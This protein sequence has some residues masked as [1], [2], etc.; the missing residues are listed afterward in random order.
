[1]RDPELRKAAA[2]VD[3]SRTTNEMAHAAFELALIKA[4]NPGHE[5]LPALEHSDNPRLRVI[6][7]SAVGATTLN[8]LPDVGA[9]NAA[10]MMAGARLG[11]VDAL[12]KHGAPT[13]GEFGWGGVTTAIANSV[14]ENAYKPLAT[15]GLEDAPML[16]AKSSAIVTVTNAV[17]RSP[18]FPRLTVE[19]QL[20]NAALSDQDAQ[21]AAA[22]TDTSSPSAY[23]IAS[24]LNPRTDVEAVLN[25]LGVD[26]QSKVVWFL[27]KS[28]AASYHGMS[29]NDTPKALDP[30]VVFPLDSLAVD[31]VLA[32][33]ATAIGFALDQIIL[34]EA[35]QASLQMSDD[36]SAGAQNLV[37]LWQTG[38]T[39]LR[40]ERR[41]KFRELREAAVVVLENVDWSAGVSP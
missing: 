9:Q 3:L 25:A 1:M 8:D 11:A 39:A 35:S 29:A 22:L 19:N 37:P 31:S 17:L 5:F 21:L 6:A 23:V 12:K 15:L 24:A 18:D 38:S 7:K 30:R 36:P 27:G 33:D 28:V 20:R 32:I 13:I 10:W 4:A 41:L 40:C 16:T 34:D 2:R 14:T 26:R